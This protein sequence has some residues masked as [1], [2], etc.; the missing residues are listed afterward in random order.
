MK[1]LLLFISMALVST[2][3]FADAKEDFIAAVMKSCGKSKKDAEKMATHGRAGNI[4]KW[5]TC[6]TPSLDIGGCLVQCPSHVKVD[7]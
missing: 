5:Q 2:S 3:V 6:N 1:A 4:I 7:K